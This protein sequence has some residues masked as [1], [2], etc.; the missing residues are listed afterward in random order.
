G[1]IG[2]KGLAEELFAVAVTVS[3]GCVK[4][5]AAEIDGP[6][7]GG[8]RFGVVGTGPAGHTPHAIADFADLPIG[9]AEGAVMQDEPPY[10]RNRLTQGTGE[11]ESCGV[12]SSPRNARTIPERQFVPRRRPWQKAPDRR[13]LRWPG[14]LVAGNRRVAGRMAGG[15]TDETFSRRGA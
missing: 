7:E 5:I 3:P 15:G 10:G 9:T 11:A 8:E 12:G 4:K 1:R 2:A 13:V 6:R 14:F